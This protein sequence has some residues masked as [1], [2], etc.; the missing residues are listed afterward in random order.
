MP[1]ATAAP[2]WDAQNGGW[3]LSLVTP[4][5]IADSVAACEV[6]PAAEGI[7]HLRL[8]WTDGSTDSV[9]LRREFGAL[10]AG[11]GWGAWRRG[12]DAWTVAGAKE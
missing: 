2:T 8:T 3:V 5:T 1:A 9:M 10:P 12:D 11:D 4:V 7:A 6:L